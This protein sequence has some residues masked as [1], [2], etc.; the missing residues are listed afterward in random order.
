MSCGC[1]NKQTTE[2]KPIVVQSNNV[3]EII[4]IPNP[5]YTIEDIIRMKDYLTSTNK[6]ETERKFASD[7]LLNAFGDLIPDYCDIACMNHIRSRLIYM[8]K[9]VLDYTN[10]NKNK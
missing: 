4:D 5:G 8:E 2:P 6:T 3:T 1:K 10:F 9:K 7:T